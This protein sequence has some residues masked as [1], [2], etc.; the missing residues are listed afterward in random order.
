MNDWKTNNSKL[1]FLQFVHCNEEQKNLA[2]ELF[3][4]NLKLSFRICGQQIS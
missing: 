2:D 4:H 3:F 1:R